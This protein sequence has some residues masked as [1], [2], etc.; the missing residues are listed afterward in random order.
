MSAF[1][2]DRKRSNHA[3]VTYDFGRLRLLKDIPG[4]AVDTFS[5]TYTS[6]SIGLV[7]IP[8][9]VTLYLRCLAKLREGLL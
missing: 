1:S 8:F 2:R 4:Q 3:S 6:Q 5:P 7:D 9:V